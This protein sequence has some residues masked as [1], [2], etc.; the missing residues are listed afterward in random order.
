VHAR[1]AIE[2]DGSDSNAYGILG[3][4]LLE[5]GKYEDAKDAY[6]KMM[7]LDD[8][9]YARSRLAGL[10]S[11]HGDSAGAVADLESAIAAGKE[12][13]QPAETSRGRNG[14]SAVIILRLEI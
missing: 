7:Q 4:A 13:K 1:K 2:M 9:L 14:S 8:G 5:V 3:D 10:K 11:L 6:E 12:A